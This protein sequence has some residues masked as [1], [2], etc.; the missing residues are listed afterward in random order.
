MILV[1]GATGL[2]GGHLLWHLLQENEQVVA[3]RRGTSN[4]QP[5]KNI[6]RFYTSEPEKYLERVLWRT[7]DVLDRESMENAMKDINEIYHCAAV[8]TLGNHS[9]NIHEIN[10]QGTRN[11]IEIAMNIKIRKFCFVSSIAACGVGNDGFPADENSKWEDNKTRTPYS[12]SKYYSENVVREA[13][14]SG[15]NAVIVN[16]GVILGFSGT[17]TGSSQIFSFVRKGLPFYID[18]GSGYVCVCDVVRAMIILMKS[19]VHSERYILVEGNYSNYEILKKIAKAFGK[20]PPFI[21]I[22]QGLIYTLG[23]FVEFAGKIFGFKPLFDK[24][25]ARSVTNRTYY[26]S[27]KIIREFGFKF[28]S[29]ENCI[30]KTCKFM[31][32]RN[33]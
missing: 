10:V 11:V 13:T 16:P 18:G 25:L 12:R 9:G 5:L 4:V 8:V 19:N 3:I 2:V 23:A 28:S 7:A 24:N 21:K 27:E 32:N 6:F 30:D 26:S 14:K 15:L 20:N 17:N 22:S 1:T 29:I 33:V 31:M